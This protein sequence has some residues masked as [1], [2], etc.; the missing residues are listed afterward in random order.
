MHYISQPNIMYMHMAAYVDA[1]V[2][3]MVDSC[4]RTL[5]YCK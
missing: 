5:A 4:S 2:I 3:R 1:D